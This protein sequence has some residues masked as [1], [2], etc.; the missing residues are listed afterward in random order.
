MDTEP[1]AFSG[2]G[3][4]G[5]KRPEAGFACNVGR[6]LRLP[7]RLDRFVSQAKIFFQGGRQLIKSDLILNIC[8]YISIYEIF[9]SK[10]EFKC[11]KMH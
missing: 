11:G 7:P 9:L 1:E 5:R 6:K 3:F 2:T 8:R 4:Q 10:N